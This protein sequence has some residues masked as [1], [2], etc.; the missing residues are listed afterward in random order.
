MIRNI[1]LSAIA[2]LKRKKMVSFF[3]ILTICLGM[4]L[5]VL[6][7]S[8]YNSFTGNIGP[9]INRDRS[10]FL[11]DMTF[12]QDGELVQRQRYKN[13][14]LGFIEEHLQT[15]ETPELICIYGGRSQQ[16]NIGTKYKPKQVKFLQTDANFWKIHQFSFLS[17]RGF[18]QNEIDQKER[19]CVISKKAAEYLF[20]NEKALGK[21]CSFYDMKYRVVGVIENEHPLFEAAADL[22]VPYSSTRRAEDNSYKN[23]QTNREVYYNRGSYKALLLVG[24]NSSFSQVKSEYNAL[25]EKLNKRGK[26]EEFEQVKT[27]LKSP[28]ELI[29]SLLFRNGDGLDMAIFGLMILCFL[30]VPVIILSNINLYALRDRVEEIGVRKSY[31]ANRKM[32]VLQ[33]IFENI[34]ITLI[35]G[36]AALALALPLNRILSN[37]L[38]QSEQIVGMDLN[39][40][41]FMALIIGAVI[42]GIITVVIPAFRISKVLPAVAIQSGVHGNTSG[43]SFKARKKWLQVV[44]HL[45]LFSVLT[46]GCFFIFYVSLNSFSGV[47]FNPKNTITLM[48]HENGKKE[49]DDN[50]NQTRFQGF[51]EKLLK[52]PEVEQ[53]S[54]VLENPPDWIV[55]QH[56]EYNFEGDDLELRTLETDTCFFK[57]LELKAIEG[58]LYTSLKNNGKYI[59]GVAT[60]AAEEKYFDGTA[61]GK[62]LRRDSDGKQVMIVGVVE[63]YKHHPQAMDFHGIFTC[64]NKASRSVVI[65][66]HPESNLGTL[67]DKIENV[68]NS[69]FVNTFI[70]HNEDI[71]SSF[72]QA[73]ESMK[74]PFYG[75][76]I[77]LSFLLFNALLGF[78]TL[79]WYNVSSRIKELGVHKAVGANKRNIQ[80]KI[81]ME[82]IWFMLI[83]SGIS[84]LLLSQFVLTVLPKDRIQ[85]FWIGLCVAFL[86]SLL[87]TIIS[88]LIPANKAAK[89]QPVDALADE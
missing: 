45:I 78:F 85:F 16:W 75:M 9:Y 42:F 61:I 36:L 76:L 58:D 11:A 44:T 40:T 43:M 5:V 70:N 87:M 17:G 22:Y 24:K 84:A 7:S 89:L 31:G 2:S 26:V 30:M 67:D 10:L 35:G 46:L 60:K 72:N 1:L 37:V 23:S 54:Y 20:Q 83:G 19:V 14:S 13:A 65:K 28:V 68:V 73:I 55:P 74:P 52:I 3:T 39:L 48:L 49:Y 50:Y 4:T 18:S 32:V 34:I 29:P 8:L 79:I 38:F 47:G 21:Q 77:A 88:A 57:L 6:M 41:F 63:K 51:R 69:S 27:D 53:V 64:R 15:L 81:L 71:E 25:C 59:Y 62:I 86:V 56:M 82:N 66:Y 12:V 33:F 80:R